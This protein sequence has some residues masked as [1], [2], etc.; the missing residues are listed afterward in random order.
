MSEGLNTPEQRKRFSHR[1]LTLRLVLS[2][3]WSALF[4]N[5]AQAAELY[6]V[7]GKILNI[8]NAGSTRS[9]MLDTKPI[10]AVASYDQSAVMVSV[11]GY[12]K[13]DDL[14]SC[15]REVPVHVH[16]IPDR[17]G[18]L[19]DINLSKRIYVA[20]DFVSTRPFLYLATVAHI[21]S[22]KNL[23]TLDGAY[24]SG[25]PLAQLKRH[26][27]NATGE[28]GASVISLD[29]RY[30]APDG[31]VSC[32]D[33]AFPGVWD[34]ESNNRAVLD[35]DSCSALFGSSKASNYQ[36]NDRYSHTN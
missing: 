32:T 29:G 11:R 19:S 26:A 4:F 9:C 35:D 20:L 23:V 10:Y 16:T 12:V 15:L 24:I 14:E 5:V 25:R 36:S 28:A 31:V 2:L 33:D 8:V 18:F 6:E 1:W 34:V 7:E 22:A 30:V 3:V 21:G 27:F 17:V 13:R